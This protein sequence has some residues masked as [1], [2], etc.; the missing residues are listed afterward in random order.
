MRPILLAV[1][2]LSSLLFSGC[3][4]LDKN[5]WLNPNRGE[6][7]DEGDAVSKA[8]RSDVPIEK[9]PDAMGNW[10]Y[11]PQYRAIARNVGAED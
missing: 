2:C 4:L 10:L 9:A 5:S 11:S 1:L 6:F 7:H 8:G 3:S